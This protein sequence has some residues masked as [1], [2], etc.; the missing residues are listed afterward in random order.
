MAPG[1][2]QD[3]MLVIDDIDAARDELIGRG[4]DVSRS[5]TTRPGSSITPER[6]AGFP[7]PT[8][9]GIPTAAS[10]RSAIPTATDGCSRRSRSGFPAAHDDGRRR[11]RTAPA[12][13]DRAACSLRRS[14]H[15]TTGGTGTRRTSTR[16]SVGATRTGPPRL[17]ALHG[18]GQ[19]HRR[20]ALLTARP[21]A[22]LE[23]PP[24]SRSPPLIA[25][26]CQPSDP[27]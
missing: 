8:R 12:R 23:S 24:L 9:R 20:P 22:G 7:A 14:H 2:V 11:T 4:V 1:S 16:A 15:H 6:P 26:G 13:D 17:R 19:G 18:G 5:G 10:R 21:G 25:R 27:A 3:L